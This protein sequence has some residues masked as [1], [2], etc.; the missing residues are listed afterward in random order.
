[1]NVAETP[2]APAAADAVARRSEIQR[3]ADDLT[4]A[5]YA[6]REAAPSDDDRGACGA[7]W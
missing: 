5:L 7:G 3:R 6:L 2:A 4:Q 1:M